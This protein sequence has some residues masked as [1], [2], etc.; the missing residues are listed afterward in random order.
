MPLIVTVEL[1]P[2]LATPNPAATDA[3]TLTVS[4]VGTSLAVT[5]MSPLNAVTEERLIVLPRRRP[6]S[7]F[8]PARPQ[9]RRRSFPRPAT[10]PQ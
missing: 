3:V 10:P 7:R 5:A 6:Q 1:A 4:T 8:Q 2:A 9:P